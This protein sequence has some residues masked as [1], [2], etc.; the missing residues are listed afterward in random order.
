[1]I[2]R[3]IKKLKRMMGGLL[4]LA[5]A[6][7]FMQLVSMGIAKASAP[8]SLC[9]PSLRCS[10]NYVRVGASH[11]NAS[12]TTMVAPK[13]R[14]D[15]SDWFATLVNFN[16]A[17]PN[18]REE[19]IS[20]EKRAAIRELLENM[21]T[22]R[23]VSAIIYN[24]SFQMKQL[25]PLVE[26]DILAEKMLGFSEK[27]KLMQ[28][29][30]KYCENEVFG[31]STETFQTADFWNDAIRALYSAYSRY[32]TVEELKDLTSFY[33]SSL[34]KKFLNFQSQVGYDVVDELMRRYA[35]Q[36]L[37]AIRIEVERQV[38]DLISTI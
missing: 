11:L 17:S 36:S 13:E 21:G 26:S 28:S 15:G 6:L 25:I 8:E 37:S 31:K 18:A 5:F 16:I 32:Y 19:I 34:G 12:H 3:F 2:T 27:E 20:S 23:I 35:A 33:R 9:P 30:Q 22:S 14:R 4:L 7:G 1:M 29:L 38:R 24:I 10:T